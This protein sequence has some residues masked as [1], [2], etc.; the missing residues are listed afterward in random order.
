M[1]GILPDEVI[2][3]PKSGFT[4]P[5]SEWIIRAFKQ[6]GGLLD[7][8]YLVEHNIIDGQ[9]CTQ[10]L[11]SHLMKDGYV[12]NVAFRMLT[13]EIWCRAFMA[14]NETCIQKAEEHRHT[15]VSTGADAAQQANIGDVELLSEQA[16]CLVEKIAQTGVLESAEFENRR[17]RLQKL[18]HKLNLVITARRDQTGETLSRVRRGK[19]TVEAYGNNI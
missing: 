7:R 16:T 4:P 15:V 17:E 6:Y 19:K 8:G 12:Q 13:L 9:Q 5:T 11:H 14:G 18:Y 2:N 1:K 10:F 3:R